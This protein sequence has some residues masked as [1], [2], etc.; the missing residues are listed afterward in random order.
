M[1]VEEIK[2]E[3]FESKIQLVELDGFGN[4]L[5]SEDTIFTIP[6]NSHIGEAHPFFEGISGLLADVDSRIH[7]PCVN[8]DIASSNVI[9][10]VDILNEGNKLYLV[11]FD[12]T[13]HYE[14]SHPLVQEKNETVIARNKL[15]FE[16]TLLTAKEEFKNKFL[17]NLNHEI[18]NP[19]NSL[20]GFMEVLNESNLNYNQKEILKI[21]QKTGGHLKVLMDDLLDISKIERG[22]LEI[23]NVPFQPNELLTSLTKHFELK[24]GSRNIALHFETK[25]K[26]PARIIGDPTRLNQILFNLLENAFR[27]TTQGIITLSVD[28]KPDADNP[29]R[30]WA[31]LNVSDTGVGISEENLNR[32]FDSYYQIGLNEIEP[33]GD[34]IGLK[35]VKDL[36][37]LMG[38]EVSV[39]SEVGKGSTFSLQLPFEKGKPPKERKRR[40]TV[41]GSGIIRGKKVLVIENNEVD[42]MLFMKM[43]VNSG[44]YNIEIAKSGQQA[45]ELL[46][47]RSYALVILKTKIPDLSGQE[48]IKLIRGSDNQDLKDIPILVVSGNVL[49][50]QQER[51]LNSGAS[52]FLAKPYTQAELF[53]AIKRLV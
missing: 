15:S 41:K 25:S 51:L 10:D 38:G 2:G 11:I 17:A 37:Q 1:T 46:N 50:E 8:L 45:M 53:R 14:R 5:K 33:L 4:V 21:M 30:V 52:S 39:A 9:A 28:M 31:N 32:V 22:E 40:T 29:E 49:P 48:L 13:D 24:Y 23:K 12:F 47:K 34:G 3:I 6:E 16:M 20:L 27:N 7:F 43:F 35:I 26:I 42:Q 18:R 44:D 36:V 19:L